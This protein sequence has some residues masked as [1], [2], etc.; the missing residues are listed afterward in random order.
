MA[1]RQT[2]DVYTKP[3]DTWVFNTTLYRPNDDVDF[4]RISNQVK[5]KLA[6]GSEARIIP[7]TKYLKEPLKLIW[8]NLDYSETLKTT[9]EGFITNHTQVKIV[10]HKNEDLIGY[11]LYIR[12]V[13]ISGVTDKEDLEASFDRSE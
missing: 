2:W 11:F 9:I 1:T 5:L 12:R 3:S 8:L 7:S 4:S 10:T 6:D 13:W